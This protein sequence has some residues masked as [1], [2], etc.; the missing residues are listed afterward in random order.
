MSHMHFTKRWILLQ[1]CG[2]QIGHLEQLIALI[3]ATDNEALI[4]LNTKG[5]SSKTQ[6][7]KNSLQASPIYALDVGISLD[8][9]LTQ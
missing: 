1:P 9:S 2:I 4:C 5:A 3:G 8:T 7:P 6:K